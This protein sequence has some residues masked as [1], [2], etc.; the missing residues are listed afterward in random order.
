MSS[1]S[2]E[3]RKLLDEWVKTGHCFGECKNW[4]IYKEQHLSTEMWQGLEIDLERLA[5]LAVKGSKKRI[6]ECL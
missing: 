6:C 3:A 1:L 2:A 5:E 4:E